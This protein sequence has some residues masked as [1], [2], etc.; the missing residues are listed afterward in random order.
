M[1]YVLWTSTGSEKKAVSLV[2]DMTDRSFVPTKTLNLK[3][4]GEWTQKDKALFPG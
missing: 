2:S 1:W 4:K 3:V